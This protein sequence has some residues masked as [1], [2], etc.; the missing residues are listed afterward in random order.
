MK[1]LCLLLKKE[2]RSCFLWSSG[3]SATLPVLYSQWNTCMLA[4]P[5]KRGLTRHCNVWRDKQCPKLFDSAQHAWLLQLVLSRTLE[6]VQQNGA[7]N[8]GIQGK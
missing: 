6:N 2:S 7:T 1:M 5:Q 3:M 8:V 4:H